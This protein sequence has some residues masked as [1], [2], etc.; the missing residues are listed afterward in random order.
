MFPP[1]V[2]RYLN[3]RGHDARS[4]ADLGAH[5]LPDDVLI[6][7]AANEHRVIVTENA[8]DFAQVTE[9]AVLLVRKAWWSPEALASALAAAL[10]RWA[11]ANPRPSPWAHWLEPEYR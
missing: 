2:T 10:S 4:P 8:A 5:N 6:A 3:E 9:C 1:D 11:A 7:I